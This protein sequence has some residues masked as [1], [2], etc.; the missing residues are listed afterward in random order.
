MDAERTDPAIDAGPTIMYAVQTVEGS[1]N[2]FA[3]CDDCLQPPEACALCENGSEFVGQEDWPDGDDLGMN[4][5]DG[6]EWSDWFSRKERVA[7]FKRS[8]V[9]RNKGEHRRF[10]RAHNQHEKRL[11]A[12]RRQGRKTDA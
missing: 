12:M 10:W 8:S 2:D 9:F 7:S 4:P 11:S 1:R 3:P 5:D 6:P